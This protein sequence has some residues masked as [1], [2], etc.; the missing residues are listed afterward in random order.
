LVLD[1]ARGF[2]AGLAQLFDDHTRTL[3]VGQG[4]LCRASSA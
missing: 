2:L 3:V 1:E 4:T